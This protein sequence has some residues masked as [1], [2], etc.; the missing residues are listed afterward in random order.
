ML[1]QVQNSHLGYFSQLLL[2]LGLRIQRQHTLPDGP[3]IR[4]VLAE[5]LSRSHVILLT[6]GLGPTSDDLTRFLVS[7][8]C[9]CPLEYHPEIE[10][11]IMDYFARRRITPP[12]SV[13]VQAQIPRSAQILDNHHGTAPGFHLLHQNC[14]LFCLPGPPSELYPMFEEQV[15]PL[16]QQLSPRTAA[17]H[18]RSFRI[19]GLGESEVQQRV[20]EPLLALGQVEIGYCARYREVDLRLISTDS[21]LLDR[22]AQLVQSEFQEFIYAQGQDNMEQVVIHLARQQG[23]QLSTA[24]SCTGGLLAHRLTNVPGASAVFHRG[25]VSYSNTSKTEELGVPTVTLDTHGAVSA[26]TAEEMARGALL[27]SGAD[28]AV[29]LTG[30]A[31]PE[32]GSPEKPVGTLFLA[33]AEK[34]VDGTISC[35]T[36]EKRLV[37]RREVFKTMASQAALD[38]FRRA[39][40]KHN[41]RDSALTT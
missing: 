6:G 39:L 19:H 16:L 25:W 41:Q 17:I 10:A 7:D 35:L 9:H 26:A 40:L 36:E 22:M 27:R 5:S 31:G 23:R 37:P 20:E 38:L 30:I 3:I 8:L 1:G 33:L 14:H 15:I 32:G 2:P 21:A 34:T 13:K 11:K 18:C 24:E 28:L 12:S 29:S 4:D